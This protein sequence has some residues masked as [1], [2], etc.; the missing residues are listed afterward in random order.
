MTR[1]TVEFLELPIPDEP[2]ERRRFL[3][4]RRVAQRRLAWERRVERCGEYAGAT[5]GWF[6]TGGVK[7]VQFPFYTFD[8]LD[9]HGKPDYSKLSPFIVCQELIYIVWVDVA[10]NKHPLQA[11]VVLSLVVLAFCNATLMREFIARVRAQ[12]SASDVTR[13]VR[14][15]RREQ[16]DVTVTQRLINER[17]EFD[18]SPPRSAPAT[19]AEAPE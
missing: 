14:E 19:G 2:E 18:G 12:F 17:H 5:F 9:R 6:Y 3:K 7:F 4:E 13:S 8:L 16:V 15:D 11:S 1:P 10:Q